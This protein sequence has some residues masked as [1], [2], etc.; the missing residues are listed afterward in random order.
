[1]GK[2]LYGLGEILEYNF[3]VF[4]VYLI[5]NVHIVVFRVEFRRNYTESD[6]IGSCGVSAR[7]IAESEVEDARLIKEIER[8]GDDEIATL[9]VGIYNGEKF[10]YFLEFVHDLRFRGKTVKTYSE[11]VSGSFVEHRRL[12]VETRFVNSY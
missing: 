2:V 4:S 8:S 10:A 12:F 1:M 7:R 5:E 9:A 6:A 3:V 11:V